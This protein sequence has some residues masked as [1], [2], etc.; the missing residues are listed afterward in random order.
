MLNSVQTPPARTRQTYEKL[1]GLRAWSAI[2]VSG[3]GVATRPSAALEAG[4]RTRVLGGKLGS[5]GV[6]ITPT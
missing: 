3:A 6:A 1:S 5:E 4:R 2:L